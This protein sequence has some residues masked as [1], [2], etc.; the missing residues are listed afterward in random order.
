MMKKPPSKD[1]GVSRIGKPALASS[2]SQS[3]M[4]AGTTMKLKQHGHAA[5]SSQP[6]IKLVN[7]TQNQTE[8]KMAANFAKLGPVPSSSK[9]KEKETKE[10]YDDVVRPTRALHAQMQARV[11][12]QL[13]QARQDVPVVPSESIELPDINSEYVLFFFS[14]LIQP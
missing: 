7:T 8:N 6:T 11:D 2:L 5:S 10:T 12:A 3:Q 13:L 4:G 14:F 1:K 9:G